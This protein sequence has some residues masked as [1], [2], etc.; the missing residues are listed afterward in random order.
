MKL[1]VIGRICP[2]CDSFFQMTQ[3]AV[4]DLHVNAEIQ[5][6]TE[7]KE[8]LKKFGMIHVPALAADGKVLFE[9]KFPTSEKMK[10]KLAHLKQ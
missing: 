9:G 10:E 5:R 1:E 8:I 2:D 4:K 6:V 3:D 7:T